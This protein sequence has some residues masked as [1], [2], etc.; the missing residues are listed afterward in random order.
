[1]L[2][3]IRSLI[4]TSFEKSNKNQ[5]NPISFHCEVY[6]SLVFAILRSFRSTNRKTIFPENL[7]RTFYLDT[8]QLE[9]ILAS[10]MNP[11]VRVASLTFAIHSA[12]EK[13]IFLMMANEPI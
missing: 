4:I 7:N 2:V 10:K 13:L 11:L 8:Q 5:A 3:I 6:G 1:M 9:L 12:N